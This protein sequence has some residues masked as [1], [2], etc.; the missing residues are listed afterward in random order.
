MPLTPRAKDIDTFVTLDA[1]LQ[2]TA[3]PFGMCNTPGTFQ[4]LVNI[5]PSGLSGCEVCLEDNFI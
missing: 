4:W 5:V 2:Y 3:M 1:F